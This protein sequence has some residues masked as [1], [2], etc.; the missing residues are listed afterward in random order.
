M[1]R[2]VGP[3]EMVKGG[4][5]FRGR[6]GFLH[7]LGAGLVAFAVKLAAGHDRAGH[8]KGVAFPPVV[9]P[10][11]FVHARRAAEFAVPHDERVV[12]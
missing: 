3:E 9:A 4:G 7:W 6:H 8:P 12:E 11:F 5:D 10:G 1:P 2:G